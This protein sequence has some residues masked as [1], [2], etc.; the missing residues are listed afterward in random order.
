MLTLYFHPVS[1]FSQ[2]V[3]IVLIEK[4]IQ[5]EMVEV[6]LFS[7]AQHRPEY[8]ARN[9][10]GRVP[11]IEED[12]LVLYE[13]TAILEYLEATRPSPSLLPAD[14]R[15]RARAS[16]LI[17]LCD[18]ELAEPAR[19]ILL[20]KR[21]LPRERWRTERMAEAGERIQKHFDILEQ[22]L[23]DGEYLVGDRFSLA[24]VCYAPLLQFV[25]MLEVQM[26]PKTAAWADSV[27][28]RPSVKETKLA[29]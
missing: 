15:L 12:G 6:D 24:E 14:L 25:G 4:Q 23:G 20:P 3:R 2:R 18:L 27:L 21:F 17:K 16:M 7:R 13:S 28:E 26:G 22:Q 9:P 5:A 29:R 19:T 10:Y 1:T 8:L 11:T